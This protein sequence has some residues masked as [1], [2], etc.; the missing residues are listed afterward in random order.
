M[1]CVIT[2][3][4]SLFS[5]NF[6]KT[7]KI[8]AQINK[9]MPTFYCGCKIH[10]FGS[11][12]E[13]DLKSCKYKIRKNSTRA[14]RIEWEH[15]MP[16]WEFGH[17]CECWSHGGRRNCAK[18]EFYKVME[19][20]LHNIEPAIGEIN[21]DRENYKYDEWVAN[22]SKST[23]GHCRIQIDNKNKRIDPSIRSR[24]IIARTYLYMH[25]RYRIPISKKQL[26]LFN[27]WNRLYPATK[28]EN[29][30][31]K[32]IYG[33]Q[34]TLNKYIKKSYENNKKIRIYQN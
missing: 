29:R 30:K 32:L 6:N 2:Y 11:K 28:F 31:N 7:K 17:F 3:N 13:P 19:N 5:L 15:V 33:I 1:L 25:D 16:A 9:G 26:N 10:W 27:K 34:H 4:S 18:D 24:G 22:K 14:H 12:G 8:A 21:A 23:Y 20:D